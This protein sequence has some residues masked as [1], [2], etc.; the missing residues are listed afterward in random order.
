V[1]LLFVRLSSKSAHKKSYH[2]IYMDVYTDVSGQMSTPTLEDKQGLFFLTSNSTSFIC[3]T[4]YE[5]LS[6][7]C[8]QILSVVVVCPFVLQKC[9]QKKLSSYIYGRIHR[10]LWTNVHTNF[11]GQ[12]RTFLFLTSNSTSFIC[13]TI[14]DEYLSSNCL[15][16]LSVVVVCPPPDF[17]EFPKKFKKFKKNSKKT[18]TTWR[19]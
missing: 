15:Q 8:L 6:S 19:I 5:Y 7:N 18:S 1:L 4:I 9:T 12:I 17:S 10:R 14:Y 11:G 13:S 3:S 2:H 16:K